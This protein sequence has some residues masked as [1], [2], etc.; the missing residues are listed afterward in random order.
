MMEASTRESSAAVQAGSAPGTDDGYV[1]VIQNSVH[2]KKAYLHICLYSCHFCLVF[3]QNLREKLR[4]AEEAQKV[5]QKDCETYKKVLADTVRWIHYIHLLP[6][7][8]K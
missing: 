4:E 3:Q 5:L 1:Q 7:N 6:Y 2:K 8:N